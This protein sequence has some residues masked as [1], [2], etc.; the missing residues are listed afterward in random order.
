MPRKF[1]ANEAAKYPRYDDVIKENDE[2]RAANLAKYGPHSGNKFRACPF[3]AL[4][5]V[6]RLDELKEHA[7]TGGIRKNKPK[8]KQKKKGKSTECDDGE[9]EEEAVQESIVRPCES[10][11]V[12]KHLFGDAIKE[13]E[14]YELEELEPGSDPT[15]RKK[16]FWWEVKRLA[17]ETGKGTDRNVEYINHHFLERVKRGR[18]QTPP[19]R[20][21][22]N[23]KSKQKTKTKKKW[24]ESEFRIQ[25]HKI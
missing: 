16:V 13:R 22:A 24:K 12:A 17:E 10:Y 3:C 8:N 18:R 5:V 19:Y 15:D 23:A 21:T 4:A 6:G 25:T 7:Y 2:A 11:D 20:Q 1:S 9:E 14:Q